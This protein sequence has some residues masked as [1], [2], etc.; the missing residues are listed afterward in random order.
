M[1]DD[2]GGKVIYRPEPEHWCVIPTY[3]KDEYPKGTVWQCDCGNTYVSEGMRKP[4]YSNTGHPAATLE[5]HRETKRE[6]RKRYKRDQGLIHTVD[7]Q[8]PG[9]PSQGGDTS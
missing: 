7:M 5:W 9:C 3:P 8:T 6:K 1:P 2:I 4:Y